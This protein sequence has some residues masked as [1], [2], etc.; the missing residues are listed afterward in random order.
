MTV[1]QYADLYDTVISADVSG[2]LE[3]WQP[4]EPF[5]T[6]TVP[7]MWSFKSSTDLYEF[8][9]SRSTP[10]S[11]TI[12]PDQSHFVTFSISDRH[13]RVFNLLSGKMI[14]KIDESLQAIQEMQQAGTAVYR[15]DDMEFGRR[16]A[17][18]R[19]IE[20]DE[21]ACKSMNAIWDESGNFI[22]YPTLLGI[23]GNLHLRQC[24]LEI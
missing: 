19:E 9:K 12:S 20:E 3:Y 8:K 2:F 11:L 6:P 5:E 18:E 4:T 1:V 7:G 10:T 15:V 22:L 24:L 23:K 21:V 13:I 16:L 14:K 17:I